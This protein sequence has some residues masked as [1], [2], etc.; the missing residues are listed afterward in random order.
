MINTRDSRPTQFDEGIKDSFKSIK[1]KVKSSAN[2]F[3]SRFDL[4]K[5]LK[6]D[7]KYLKNNPTNHSGPEVEEK[8]RSDVMKAIAELRNTGVKFSGGLDVFLW[9]L[10]G[11]YGNID[12]TAKNIKVTNKNRRE[13]DLRSQ[14]GSEI[15]E[16]NKTSR[17]AE[18][19][20]PIIEK[21]LK[22]RYNH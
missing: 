11:N 6:D 14:F 12:K 18:E 20:K 19:L 2:K 5:E 17:L 21:M 8:F 22:E 4:P 3:M 16:S 7:L 13:M 9:M 1:G 10:Y 15:D